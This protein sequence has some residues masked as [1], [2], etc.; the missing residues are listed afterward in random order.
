MPSAAT[1]CS[2]LTTREA[3]ERLNVSEWTVR[4]LIH[5]SADPLPALRV[6]QQLRIDERELSH[7]LYEDPPLPTRRAAPVSPPPAGNPERAA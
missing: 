6:G 3:A 5:R 2:L 4:R 1:R 7:W